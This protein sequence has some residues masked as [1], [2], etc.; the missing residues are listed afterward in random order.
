M[1]LFCPVCGSPV[2]SRDLL[3][4]DCA[5]QLDS[6]CFDS[7]MSRCPVCFYPKA[8][9]VYV[10]DLC[11]GKGRR[12]VFSVARYD[13]P[14][15]YSI[16]DSFKFHDRR[17]LSK[18]VAH[19]LSRAL[20]VLDPMNKAILVPVPC[21]PQRLLEHGWDP[22]VDV[23]KDLG[24]P[25]L[26]LLKNSDSRSEGPQK[27]LDRAGRM[28]SASGRFGIDPDRLS[29]IVDR[30]GCSLVVVDD[31]VTTMSTMNAAMDV[32]ASAGFGHV[33]GASWLCEL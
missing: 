17:R 30:E 26:A 28:E 12:R 22:M 20:D 7:F 18:V 8:N 6:E 24:R 25:W 5:E 32:L 4:Q 1:G 3:C 13:G 14:L 23:C 16:L 33:S 21:S 10:C 29:G 9:D 2:L 19:Y 15:S 11:K 27:T 31:V